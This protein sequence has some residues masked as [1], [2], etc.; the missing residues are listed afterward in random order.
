MF[1]PSRRFKQKV[2]L[3]GL[4]LAAQV[5][6]GKVGSLCARPTPP[7]SVIRAEAQPTSAG[8]RRP[9]AATRLRDVSVALGLAR[10]QLRAGRGAEAEQTL[11][12]LHD[13]LQRLCKKLDRSRASRQGRIALTASAPSVGG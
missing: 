9:R 3:V 8:A 4:N 10:L 7:A 13:D 11:E 12:R 2:V 5:A 6:A 1:T